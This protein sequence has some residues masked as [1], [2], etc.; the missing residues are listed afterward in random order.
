[1]K[2]SFENLSAVAS[3]KKKSKYSSGVALL[4]AGVLIAPSFCKRSVLFSTQAMKPLFEFLKILLKCNLNN[5]LCKDYQPQNSHEKK[6]GIPQ[7][8][9]FATA[10]NAGISVGIIGAISLGFSSPA[11]AQL[12]LGE[13]LTNCNPGALPC[14]DPYPV[15][16]TYTALQGND[17]TYAVF[18]GGDFTIQGSSAEAEGSVFVY[19]DLNMNKTSGIYNMGWVGVGSFVVPDDQ[20]DYVTVGG[21]VNVPNAGTRIEVGGIPSN[22][23]PARGNFRH[24]GTI[25]GNVTVTAPGQ[26]IADPNL[27][28]A[29]FDAV[30]NDLQTKSMCFANKSTSSNVTVDAQT[31]GVT[32]TSTN[33]ASGI[34]II[35]LDKSIDNG[36]GGA[37][38]ITFS[39]FPDDATIIINMN[40]AGSADD[41]TIRTYGMTGVSSRL[42]ERIL[43]NFP[44]AQNVSI[45][46][47]SQ[48]WGSVLIPNRNSTT[49]IAEPGMNG[50]FI[51]GGD[52]IHNGTGNEFHNY[53]FRGNLPTDCNT[54]TPTTSI[55]GTLFEDS[56]EGDDLDATEPKLPDNITVNLVNSSNNIIKTTTTDANGNYSFAGVIAGS[57]K[58]QVDTTDTDIPSGLTLGTTNNIP[59]TLTNANLT[60]QNFGFD[61]ATTPVDPI[62]ATYCKSPYGEVYAVN[63][64]AGTA[65]L[66]AIHGPTGAATKFTSAPSSFGITAINTAATDHVNKM[67][68]YG[69]ANKIYAW[70]AIANQHIIVAGNFQSLLT[71]AGYTGK[72]VTLSSGGAAFYGGALY[73]GVDGNRNLGAT[74]PTTF[75]QDF[76]IFRVNLSADGKTAVS[77]TPLG[78]KAKSGGAF[79]TNTMDDWGDFIISDTGVILAL[80]NNRATSSAQ[81]RFWKFDLNTNTYSFV[82]NTTENAQLAKSGDGTLWGLRSASV[83]QFDNNGN[84]IGSP[85]ATTVQA[86]DGAE[87]VVGSA[88]VGDRVWSDTNGD[89]VQDAGEIGIAGVTVA[90]YRDINK[91]GVIDTGE[92]KLATQVTGT[93]GNYNFTELLPHD[94]LTGTGHNDFIVKVESGVPT[95]YTATTATQKNADLATATENLTTADFGYKLT[96]YNISGTLYEDSDGG[97]DLDTSEP[98]LPAAVTVILYKD[99]NDNNIVDPGEEVANTLTN[100]QGQYTFTNVV[101]DTY[102]VKVDTSDSD[103]PSDLTL[104]T[105]NDLT[106]NVSTASVG[107]IDFGFDK[108]VASNPNVLLVKRI[109]AV[110]NQTQNQANGVNLAGYIDDPTNA[111][112]DNTLD[113]PAPTP[114]DTEL[115]PTP[116]TQSLVGGTNGGNVMPN[117]LIEYTIYFLSAGDSTAD[118][119]WMCDYIPTHV[120]FVSTA[121]NNS[122]IPPQSGGLS[123]S[124]RGM[125]LGIGLNGSVSLESLTNDGDGDNGYYFPAGSDPAMRFPGIDCEGDG[126]GAN[127][128]PNGA[129]VVNLGSLPSAENA[130]NPEEAYGFVRF[131]GRVK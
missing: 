49:L 102:K 5:S 53:P 105:S 23:T 65:D 46:G 19:G 67:V 21:N 59:V 117:D 80:S 40:K 128:N 44:D 96:A 114:L 108:A 89:G 91:N 120:N 37:T 39:N 86:F 31:W 12:R 131:Q 4:I 38:G 61:R 101:A 10:K 76:E 71:T 100:D 32:I 90:I 94:R 22:S 11:N 125:E 82:N 124:N 24:R 113:T 116:L 60:G 58:I 25:S 55:S 50:R 122:A 20:L 118:N 15:I 41:I 75:D 88:S 35:N 109:T 98:K 123:G 54:P 64:S 69:D 66:Y 103:I 2:S 77:V 79:T 51:A 16:G 18:I 110:N 106:V 48:F 104:G 92:P 74:P 42:G 13:P 6:Y 36:S 129:I 126:N 33:G 8:L 26:I 52:V 119:V 27:D 30:F 1:M 127:A 83:V 3:V 81:R 70:D 29:P 63:Q 9:L 47:S 56:D 107:N 43:W 72:F 73:V 93:N 85:V 78:I 62:P 99:D 57:Y 17:N 34:Y 115:W 121:Y 87:C 28:L 130:D 112:D 95:G 14:P 68:Y 84:V 111:Y 7:S 97:D 45:T